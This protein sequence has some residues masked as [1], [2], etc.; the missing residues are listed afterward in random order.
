MIVVF[1]PDAAADLKDIFDYIAEDSPGR[2]ETFM[3]ELQRVALDLAAF[4]LAWPLVPR[5]E[6]FGY[7]RRPYKGYLIFFSLLDDELRV[8]RILNGAQDYERLLFPND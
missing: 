3:A 4:P 8:L 5:Y 6:G 7:R 1:A 2:A